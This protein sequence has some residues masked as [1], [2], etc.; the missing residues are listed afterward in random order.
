MG[1]PTHI[2]LYRR[3]IENT[4]RRAAVVNRRDPVKPTRHMQAFFFDM[5]RRRR[6][7]ARSAVRRWLPANVKLVIVS[8]GLL[9]RIIEKEISVPA[10]VCTAW[11]ARSHDG[12]K[13]P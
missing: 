10:M 12:K 2:P 11:T 13:T 3:M 6:Y 4:A 1:F 8:A 5:P 7:R 9:S